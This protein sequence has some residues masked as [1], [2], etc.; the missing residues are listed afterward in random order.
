MGLDQWFDIIEHPEYGWTDRVLYYIDFELYFRKHNALHNWIHRHNNTNPC[1]PEFTDDIDLSK[2]QMLELNELLQTITSMYKDYLVGKRSLKNVE[3]YCR[4][5]YPPSNGFF[6]GGTEY[7]EW[8]YRN[9][10]E[11]ATKIH[12]LV[13]PILDTVPGDMKVF[14]YKTSW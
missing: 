3:N 6:H 11:E 12:K 5:N 8:Y 14:R 1:D 7:D 4:K 2:N 10:L 13:I 9:V